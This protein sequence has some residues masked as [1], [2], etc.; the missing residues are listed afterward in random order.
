MSN[1]WQAKIRVDSKLAAKLISEQ[2]PALKDQSLELLGEGWDN[3]VYQLGKEWVF[4]FPRRDISVQLIES[5]CRLLPLIATQLPL[6]I[7]RA[8]GLKLEQFP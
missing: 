7:P 1:E 3:I 2:F 6:D 4:R 8:I 5:E